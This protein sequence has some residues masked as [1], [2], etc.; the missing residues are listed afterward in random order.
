MQNFRSKRI[1]DEM[2]FRLKMFS[3]KRRY[4]IPCTW[5][6]NGHLWGQ[7]KS[8]PKNVK[9]SQVAKLM[10]SIRV[11]ITEIRLLNE[12]FVANFRIVGSWNPLPPATCKTGEKEMH[13]RVKHRRCNLAY[14]FKTAIFI[15][16]K[17]ACI[18]KLLLETNYFINPRYVHG[19]IYYIK[20]N[21]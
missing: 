13:Y 11:T 19:T 4:A 12:R 5:R 21:K 9:Q 2:Y 7:L 6:Q 3:R 16:V 14:N 18:K 17:T 20:N 8:S 1:F 10:L 15:F